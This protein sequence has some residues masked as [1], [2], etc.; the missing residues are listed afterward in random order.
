MFSHILVA[1]DATPH[2]EAILNQARDLSLATGAAV[3]LIHFISHDWIEGQDLTMEDQTTAEEQVNRATLS[4]AGAGIEARASLVA[5]DA[6]NI[7]NEILQRAHAGPD[8]LII[9]G[10]RHHHAWLS[11]LGISMSDQ[12][13]HQSRCPV[14]LVPETGLPN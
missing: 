12:V 2:S 1:I 13:A 8:Q 6:R 4:L 5:A 7:G 3:E 10:S 9:L 11:F 14:L